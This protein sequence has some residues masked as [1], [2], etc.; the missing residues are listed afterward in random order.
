MKQLLLICTAAAVLAGCGDKNG[1]V[2]EASGTIEG[3]QV[4]IGSEV[5]GRIREVR[6]REGARLK[7][8][9]T[10]LLVDDTEYR[11]QLRQAAANEQVYD[12]SYRVAAQGSRKEDVVQAEAAYKTAEK[13]YQRMAE[14]LPA[15]TVTQK[16]FDDAYS[17]FVAA[18]QNYR[19]LKAGLRP[20]EIST[21][22]GRWEQASAQA[23]LLKKKIQDCVVRAPIDGT[24]TLRAVE[25]GELVGFGTNVFQLTCLDRVKLTIY[26]DETDIG[27]IRLG[28][29]TRVSIDAF[30]EGKTVLGSIVYISPSAEFTPKNVQ[31]KEERTKLVFA[32]KIEIPNADGALKPGLPADA[33]IDVEGPH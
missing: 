6:A 23:D 11:I 30:A 25:P 28:Q 7:A 14:L 13:D 5:A 20:E 8:G 21:A 1:R 18:E 27:R 9:D 32:V 10:L 3:T 29:A 22:R 26:L 31:T 24:V 16:Q 19:K 2:I 4:N 17:R 15:K 33:A 12:N